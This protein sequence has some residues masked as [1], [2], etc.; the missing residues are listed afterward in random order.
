MSL[1]LEVLLG[2]GP[3]DIESR[4]SYLLGSITLDIECLPRYLGMYNDT[5]DGFYVGRFYW[6][7][8][9]GVPIDC[10]MQMPTLDGARA[11]EL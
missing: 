6:A 2:L 4:G 5:P 11:F 3:L 10:T 9:Q 8:H 1:K 7:R